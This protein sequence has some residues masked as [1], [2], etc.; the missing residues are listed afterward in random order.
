MTRRLR[1][2][3]Y[4]SASVEKLKASILTALAKYGSKIGQVPE[5]QRLTVVVR[6]TMNP[7]RLRTGGRPAKGET[8]GEKGETAA[9]TEPQTTVSDTFGSYTVQSLGTLFSSSALRSVLT[10]SV[11]QGD[12]A[13]AAEG[14]LDM[15]AFMKKAQIAQY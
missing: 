7:V 2:A 9:D 13:A 12:C 1:G 8:K 11:R 5:D 14:K 3:G 4:D 10:I 15:D 6:S